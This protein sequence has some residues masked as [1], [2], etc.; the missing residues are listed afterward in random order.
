[1]KPQNS[2]LTVDKKPISPAVLPPSTTDYRP[3]DGS[4]LLSV[5]EQTY[6]SSSDERNLSDIKKH[7]HDGINSA[8]VDI[9]NLTGLIRTVAAVPTWIP[10]MFFDQLVIYKSGATIRLYI[11]DSLNK[12]WRYTA[13]T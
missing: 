8:Q 4:A 2:K 1:M 9:S 5:H 6:G 12:A 13:L 10:K 11:Y 3:D 7:N